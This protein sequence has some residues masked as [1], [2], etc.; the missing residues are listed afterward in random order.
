MSREW[1]P[2]D[3]SSIS[4]RTGQEQRDPLCLPHPY[5]SPDNNGS[6]VVQI[7]RLRLIAPAHFSPG[8]PNPTEG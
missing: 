3:A 2:A 6:L 7:A 4:S 5:A 1:G 8:E